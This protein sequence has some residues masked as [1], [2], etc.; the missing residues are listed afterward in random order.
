MGFRGLSTF[1]YV[2]L[3]LEAYHAAWSNNTL[4]SMTFCLHTKDYGT[5]AFPLRTHAATL[6]YSQ[7]YYLYQTPTYGPE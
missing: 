6:T 7:K 2:M 5:V 4:D 3:C 1:E